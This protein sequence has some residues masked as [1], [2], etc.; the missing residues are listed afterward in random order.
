MSKVSKPSRRI[1]FHTGDVIGLVIFR[2]RNS[3]TPSPKRGGI[4][5][6]T[7][8]SEEIVWYHMD[9]QV[10][11]LKIGKKSCP[12]PVGPE[13]RLKD[14]INAAPLLSVQTGTTPIAYFVSMH[15]I[16]ATVKGVPH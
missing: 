1:A 15:L 2:H 7:T 10:D 9:S 3:T 4:K 14:S 6:D 16:Q 8:F 5:L 12:L 11:P 13:R